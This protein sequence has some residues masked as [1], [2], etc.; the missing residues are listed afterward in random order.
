MGIGVWGKMGSGVLGYLGK[1]GVGFWAKCE[2]GLGVF[3][4]NG[5]WDLAKNVSGVC[6]C[7]EKM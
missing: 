4:G 2:W 5:E 6:G 7:L 3:E 1:W